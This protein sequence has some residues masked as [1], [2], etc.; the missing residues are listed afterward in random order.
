M[1]VLVILLILSLVQNLLEIFNFD[2]G[3]AKCNEVTGNY[4]VI[5]LFPCFLLH[6]IHSFSSLRESGMAALGKPTGFIKT[7]MLFG[8]A[9]LPPPQ[10]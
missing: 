7:G 4:L 9:L 2:P 6:H 8:F 1:P 10:H 3:H 5:F